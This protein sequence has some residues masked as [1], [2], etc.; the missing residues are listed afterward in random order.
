MQARSW[1]LASWGSV[2]EGGREE[3]YGSKKWLFSYCRYFY[4]YANT[5]EIK[6]ACSRT[7]KSKDDRYPE[8]QS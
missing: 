3:R 4:N 8:T 2:R 6:P 1:G 5:V 7:L